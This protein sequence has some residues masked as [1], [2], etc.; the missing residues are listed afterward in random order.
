MVA[1]GEDRQGHGRSSHTVLAVYYSS[2]GNCKL[3]GS[4]DLHLISLG[5]LLLNIVL[6][7]ERQN[8]YRILKFDC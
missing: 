5:S 3:F 2:G 7:T 6:S 1:I 4:R 8:I